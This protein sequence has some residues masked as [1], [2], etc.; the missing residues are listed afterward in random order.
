MI[1]N[2]LQELFNKKDLILG[3]MYIIYYDMDYNNQP[4]SGIILIFKHGHNHDIYRVLSYKN[5]TRTPKPSEVSGLIL[6]LVSCNEHNHPWLKKADFFRL[7]FIDDLEENNFDFEYNLDENS[8]LYIYEPGV[9]Y[10]EE[11]L[12]DNK[13]I[14]YINFEKGK[15]FKGIYT[16]VI[17]SDKTKI[18]IPKKVK[19]QNIKIKRG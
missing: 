8:K 5:P 7:E 2:Y 15:L 18:L 17:V 9:K 6:A 16:K 12:N 10:E 3:K 13:E 14:S 19:P 11:L 4:K 1:E